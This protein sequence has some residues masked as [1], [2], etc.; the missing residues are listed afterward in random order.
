M[1]MMSETVPSGSR[2]SRGAVLFAC[3]VC[4]EFAAA[5]AGVEVSAARQTQTTEKAAK[6]R[7][8]VW[9]THNVDAPIPS[10]SENPPCELSGVLEKAG[11]SASQLATD[12]E[13]FTAEERIEYKMLDRHGAPREADQGTFNYKPSHKCLRRMTAQAS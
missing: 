5:T 11:A 4:T 2:W 8:L 6:S 9:V 13:R 10:L 1:E 3:M 12:L 7:E